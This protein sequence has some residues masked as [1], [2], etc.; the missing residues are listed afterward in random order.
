ML[1]DKQK[2]S[3]CLTIFL[4]I[5]ISL[6]IGLESAP[7]PPIHHSQIPGA[8]ENEIEENVNE[9]H[10]D[11]KV[12]KEIDDLGLEYGRYLQEVVKA[13]DEDPVFSK[14]LGN[15]T[16]E[17]IMNGHVSRIIDQVAP[18]VR[19][20]LDEL[21]RI[22]LDRL[23]KLAMKE[24]RLEEEIAAEQKS[25][26][27]GAY[28]DDNDDDNNDVE[29]GRRWR[30]TTTN[31]RKSQIPNKLLDD[32]NAAHLDHSNPHT[33][34]A[35]DLQRLILQATKDLDELDKK[36]RRD[37]KQYEMEKELHYR[38]SLQNLT[39]EQK[40]EIEKKHEEV[41]KKHF[42]HP[43]VHHPGSKQ[44]LEE[45]WKE[46][47]HMPEQE[48]DPKIFFHMHDINGD[49]FLDQEEVESIL[50]IEVKKL[51]NENDPSYDRN[52]MME[53]YHRMREHIY[54]EFDTNRDGLISKKEFL[55]YSKQAEFNRD[56]GWK[57]IEEAP[58]Y[59]EEELKRYEQERRQ[60]QEHYARYGAYGYNQQP[61]MEY[62]Y[63]P[64]QQQQ[65]YQQGQPVYYQVQNPNQQQQQHHQQQ[66]QVYVVNA[67]PEHVQ[68]PVQYQ[69]VQLPQQTYQQQMPPQQ[70]QHPNQNNLPAQQQQ[71]Q[72]HPNIQNHQPMMQQQ[73]QPQ[74]I[75]NVQQYNPNQ[76]QQQHPNQ[77]GVGQQ[78][79]QQP[80]QQFN[81][82]SVQQQQQQQNQPIHP[83]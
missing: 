54:R 73:Q 44:Q 78:Q 30:T 52:E 9:I 37:F 40:V 8:S 70:Q 62:Q 34:E 82:H 13:L 51:Y 72:Y 23:R 59:T 76:Q 65:P 25:H 60:L 50:S 21:K 81:T 20:R 2:Q 77:Y 41:K 17:Q 56:E 80:N 4:V 79:Q 46:Q 38:E 63:H 55:D 27:D 1:F 31:K 43:K 32:G 58:V 26:G 67:P 75:P 12:D 68:Q 10:D 35:E 64:Q 53:E 49:G 57:G 22:E 39:A 19:N 45:V 47:D 24:H 48:F 14:K 7:R 18:D 71:Q 69:H 15:V 28:V 61:G 16:H 83:K 6:I 36:R 74:H 5:I 66:Q 42:E 11:D 33:F 29:S 3:F